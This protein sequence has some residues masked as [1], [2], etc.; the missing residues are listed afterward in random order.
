MRFDNTL[1]RSILLEVEA[2]AL[3]G[4]LPVASAEF[5]AMT[6]ENPDTA[7]EHAVLM[8]EGGW[9]GG[10][11]PGDGPPRAVVQCLTPAGA[12][13]LAAIRDDAVWAEV[14]DVD[15]K[16]GGL[17]KDL[18]LEVAQAISSRRRSGP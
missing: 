4:D 7:D 10:F 16:Y 14:E 13:V 1:F 17:P 2:R 6:P 15:A 3:R 12:E 9:L 8:V 5:G 11:L 18:L